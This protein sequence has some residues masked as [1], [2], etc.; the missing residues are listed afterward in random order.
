MPQAAP[1][2][3]APTAPAAA[4]A[5]PVALT[6]AGDNP[7]SGFDAPPAP[8][9]A[10]PSQRGEE[11]EGDRPRK[12]KKK[13]DHD[14]RDGERADEKKR[15][16]PEDRSARAHGRAPAK[17]GGGV[18]HILLFIVGGYALLATGLAA[19]G[20]FFKSGESVEQGH[21]LSTIPDNFGEFDPATRKKVSLYKFKVDG[22]L[23]AAQ[24]GKI[25]D[26]IAVGDVVIQPEEIVK[27]PL[28]LEIEGKDG[29]K[30]PRPAGIAL[31]MRM[32]I[33]NN[34]DLSIYPMDPAFTRKT[35]G[36]DRPI[37]RIV[38]NK[39]TVFAGGAIGWPFGDRVKRIMEHQQAN[40]YEPL[41]P[42]ESREYIV[43]TDTD[44]KLIEA[45]EKFKDTMQWRVQVRRS[46][47][48][49]RGKEVPV[50]AIIGVD[51][52]ASEIKDKTEIRPGG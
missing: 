47:I 1:F 39:Q 51:F 50:T 40:D 5:A 16:E 41:R 9:E 32:M 31:V 24:R 27:R 17:A 33:K 11:E 23:P 45:V 38:L 14:D 28:T 19:Y 10:A 42:G 29:E 22:E 26:K 3:A 6:P 12:K 20:L 52:T 43:F 37:T 2:Q 18:T 49:Y 48:K 44:R 46:P 34:S 21:P 35:K 8:G 7:F 4:P 15:D 30:K 36:D 25:G 13:R